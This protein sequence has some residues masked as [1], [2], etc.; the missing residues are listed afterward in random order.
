MTREQA[1]NAQYRQEFHH[2]TLKNA[3]GTPMRARVNGR[4]KTWKTRPDDFRLPMKH[5][6]Y[7][8]FY[9]DETNAGDWV[10]GNGCY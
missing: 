10:D 1:M 4:C 8:C 5:G 7:E 6:L 2:V 3:D 9:V